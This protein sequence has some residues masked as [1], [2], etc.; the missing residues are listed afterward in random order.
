MIKV[1]FH[2]L[3]QIETYEGSWSFH[4]IFIQ[5]HSLFLMKI[6]RYFIYLSIALTIFLNAL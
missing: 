2:Q 3:K 4:H 1:I 6:G 5:P